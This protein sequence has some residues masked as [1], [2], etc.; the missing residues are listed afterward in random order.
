MYFTKPYHIKSLQWA[1]IICL[2]IIIAPYNLIA[3]TVM[4][5]YPDII[6]NTRKGHIILPQKLNPG[7]I[8]SV[9]RPEIEMFSPAEG[10]SNG[11]AVIICPG[12]SYKVL[13]YQAEGIKA[14]RAFAENGTTA[15]VLKY[16]LPD[17][18]TMIDKTIGPLQDAQQAM[19][20]VR[21]NA[22]KWGIDS[23][24]IGVMGFSAGG[25][26]ASTLATHFKKP[27]IADPENISLRPD[28]LIL[29]YPVISMQGSLTHA[30]SKRNLLGLNPSKA[31]VD[32]YSNELQ[33][34]DDTPP[35]YIT[36]AGDD[37]LVSV[38][39][40]IVFYEQLRYHKVAAEMHLF[41]KGG[42]GFVLGQPT[43]TWTTP[44]FKWMQTL[45]K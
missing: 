35:T 7:L 38:D 11:T 44:I 13:V 33:V 36:H 20:F 22:K 1:K 9:S 3:Q 37:Q 31:V 19:K 17:D 21:G 25:H 8:Y 15:F 45:N 18:S 12:G 14:A 42:H 39:N 29:V 10:K 16:R 26:L 2:L 28:F 24:R 27:L 41:P 40:S 34:A 32:A 6:P 43:A 5:I 4:P 30:D 23:N